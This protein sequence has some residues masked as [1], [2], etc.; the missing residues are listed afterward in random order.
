MVCTVWHTIYMNN[1]ATNQAHE[2]SPANESPEAAT[3]AQTIREQITR[4]TL[5]CV[6]ARDFTYGQPEGTLVALT[7]RITVSR[8]VRHYIRVTLDGSDTY[9]VNL[10]TINRKL[11]LVTE[12]TATDVYCDQLDEVV[13]R[14]GSPK[15]SQRTFWSECGIELTPAAQKK[16]LSKSQAN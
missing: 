2:S 8:N 14:M 15:F 5:M 4:N 10:L 7:F 3:Y 16:Y 9:T 12:M 13:Y 6:G 1:A 11:E